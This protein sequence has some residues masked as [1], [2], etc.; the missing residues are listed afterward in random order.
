M[1]KLTSLFI[2]CTLSLCAALSS[3]GSDSSKNKPTTPATI[4]YAEFESI[5]DSNADIPLSELATEL[6][7]NEI[8]PFAPV[9]MPIQ[10]GYLPGF[11]TEIKGFTDGYFFGPMIGSIP[12]AGYVFTSDKPEALISL[13]KDK[14]DLRWNICT[15]A[16]EIITGSVNTTVY[17]VLAPLSFE[18]DEDAE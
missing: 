17:C 13:L 8:I 10:E 15:S 14:V 16:D 6:S 5:M 7:T 3:C 9:V 2:A 11:T 4:L 18:A 12:F 1:K